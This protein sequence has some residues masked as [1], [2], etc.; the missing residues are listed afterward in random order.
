MSWS[1]PSDLIERAAGRF[2]Y[3]ASPYTHREPVIQERRYNDAIAHSG[4]LLAAGVFVFAPIV[5]T[6]RA[7][8]LYALPGDF[9]FWLNYNKA[10]MD[11]SA[12]T[13]VATIDGWRESKGV[14]QEIA[15]TRETG[16]PVYRCDLLPAPAAPL[17]SLI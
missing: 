11:A 5:Q 6:H 8:G 17:L 16:K 4:A 7:A 9:V 14:A 2:Y 12:G 10:F 15:Y 3:L 1:T 13:I